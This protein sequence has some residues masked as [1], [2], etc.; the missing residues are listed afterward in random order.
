MGSL[1]SVL[2]LGKLCPPNEGGI[3]VFS[4]DLLKFLNE[5][6]IKAELLCFGSRKGR[7]SYEN[8]EYFESKIDLKLSSAPLSYD[9][10]KK[11]VEISKNYDIVHVHTPNPL[12]EF[13]SFFTDKPIVIHWHSDIVK[14]KLL[15]QFYRPIQRAV[16]KKAIKIVIT[17]PNYRDSS[18]QLKDYKHKCIVIPLG[19]DKNRLKKDSV[20]IKRI[21]SDKR[22]ILSVGRFVEYKGFKYL[23]ESAKYIDENASLVIVG[24]GPL[25]QEMRRIVEREKLGEKVIL[26][27]RVE[28]V[29]AYI[30]R[31]HLF[32]LPSISRNEAFG[33]VLVEALLFGKPLITT[34][35]EGSGMNYININGNTGFVVPPKD[36]KA[37]ANA[38]NRLLRDP[39]LYDQFSKN[40]KERFKEFEI[41]SIGQ[42]IIK[43]YEEVLDAH[44]SKGSA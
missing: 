35:V 37:I 32:C 26:T 15:Y 34:S 23:I 27:G 43:L 40:A 24:R 41:E 16:L 10:V 39:E 17:S 2:H 42:K 11:F 19:L 18:K 4:F 28:N 29:Q 8:F 22:V 5:Q 1:L 33:L 13:I 44:K 38:V 31:A 9:Y 12:A 20:D 7:F 36:P 14:Q 25:F 30:Q 3:E 6:G 21:P